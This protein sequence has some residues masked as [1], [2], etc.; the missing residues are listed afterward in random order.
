[1]TPRAVVYSAAFI[2]DLAAIEAWIA[3]RAGDHVALN[4]MR[5]LDMYC[6]RFDLAAQRGAP[7]DDLRPDLR[8]IGF[9]KRIELLFSITP[10][11]VE[12]LRAFYGGQDWE[13]DLSET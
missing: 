2:D 11:R 12:F 13:G 4:Y 5:R 7:R 9:E 10:D 6:S 8:V 1:M 3:E